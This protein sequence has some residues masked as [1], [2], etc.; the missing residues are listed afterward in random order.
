[1][2]TDIKIYQFYKFPLKKQ[3]CG[4]LI[5]SLP[6]KVF[7]SKSNCQQKTTTS[8]LNLSFEILIHLG[9]ADFLS[10][11]YSFHP[12]QHVVSYQITLIMEQTLI[13]CLENILGKGSHYFQHSQINCPEL[14]K[15]R[16]H[17]KIKTS[18]IVELCLPIPLVTFILPKKCFYIRTNQM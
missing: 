13:S 11:S 10:Y 1:M 8:D 16:F 3:Y 18:G 15:G 2:N 12:S 7:L 5:K 14:L 4:I 6:E 9:S 17:C